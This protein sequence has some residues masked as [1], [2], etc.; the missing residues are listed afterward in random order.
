MLRVPKSKEDLNPGSFSS[1]Q[2]GFG[3]G[4][5]WATNIIGTSIDS[6]I[7]PDN[8]GC[9]FGTGL[10]FLQDIE[11]INE[12]LFILALIVWRGSQIAMPWEGSH[13]RSRT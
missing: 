12:V 6:C 2:N 11:I 5:L 7:C 10:D 3:H 1:L 13:H 9:V 4:A 8:R